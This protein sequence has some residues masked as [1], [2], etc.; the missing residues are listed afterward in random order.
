ME[1]YLKPWSAPLHS[2]M[3]GDE[4][5]YVGWWVR[6]WRHLGYSVSE[7]Q[8]RPLSLDVV[9]YPYPSTLLA[10]DSQKG[11]VAWGQRSIKCVPTGRCH[12]TDLSAG[13]RT[14]INWR[15]EICSYILLF[16][17][18]HVYHFGIKWLITVITIR[19]RSSRTHML[20]LSAQ[21]GSTH[22]VWLVKM[23]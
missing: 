7:L 5:L 14:I 3:F 13:R 21:C 1:Y 23:L 17:G 6:A 9:S 11:T 18:I 15:S 4:G 2:R 12:Q 19:P 10:L 20:W 8:L 22:R 16:C